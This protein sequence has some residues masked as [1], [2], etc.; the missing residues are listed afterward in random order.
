MQRKPRCRYF[1]QHLY[2]NVM[3]HSRVAEVQPHPLRGAQ[4]LRATLLTCRTQCPWRMGRADFLR[5]GGILRFPRE[6]VVVAMLAEMQ[7]A[8][9][10]DQSI[11]SRSKRLLK[12][13]RQNRVVARPHV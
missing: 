4:I 11:Q 1:L 9:D 2:A 5:G 13:D 12:R 10:G 3:H 6:R 7:K 8:A